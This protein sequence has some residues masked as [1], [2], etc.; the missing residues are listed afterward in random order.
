[1]EFAHRDEFA[2]HFTKQAKNDENGEDDYDDIREKIS[3]EEMNSPLPVSSDGVTFDSFIRN[4]QDVDSFKEFLQRTNNKGL[5][6]F[7]NN[8]Q[9][10]N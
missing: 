1:M 7:F 3:I 9:E 4:K 10:C 2:V 6:H 5:T 8:L